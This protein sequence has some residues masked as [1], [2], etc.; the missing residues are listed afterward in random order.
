MVLKTVAFFSW[1]PRQRCQASGCSFKSKSR[2]RL[3]KLFRELEELGLGGLKEWADKG[4]I[5]LSRARDYWGL[6]LLLFRYFAKENNQTKEYS[7]IRKLNEDAVEHG[8]GHEEGSFQTERCLFKRLKRVG[9]GWSGGR[10]EGGKS[11]NFFLKNRKKN[12]KFLVHR[13]VFVFV[14][15]FQENFAEAMFLKCTFYKVYQIFSYLKPNV[16]RSL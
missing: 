9:R 3:G 14:L 4:M 5:R 13:F 10:N 15:F 1:K 6:Q 2:G 11:F 8:G 12:L 7:V 16:N